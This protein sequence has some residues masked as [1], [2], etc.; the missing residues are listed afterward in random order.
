MIRDAREVLS[1]VFGFE[2][3]RGQQQDI[4]EEVVGGGDALV[5][6]PTGGGK[7]LCFQLPA[8]CRPG[9][10]VVVS[11]LIALMQDQVESLRQLGVQAAALNSSLDYHTASE[12]ERALVAGALDLIY[13]APERLLTPGFL[14]LLERC[15]IA[16]FAIDE[17]HCVSQWGHGFRPEYRQLAPL[18]ARFP[19]VPRLAL[20]AT[21]DGPTRRDILTQLEL[22]EGRVFAASFDRPNIRYR[23]RPKANPRRQLKAFLEAEHRGDAGIVYCLSR[24]K[25]ED[26][27]Q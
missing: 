1:K 22:T 12:V 15:E 21:A 25:V 23:V 10:G 18:R 17:A 13:V 4:I 3:F 14:R 20:T 9:L 7:S 16:L 6:M 5:L 2:A 11:P 27:A 8:L 26:T 19:E 24:G